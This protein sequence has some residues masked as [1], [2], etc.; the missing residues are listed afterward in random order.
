MSIRATGY[1]KALTSEN[2]PV[3]SGLAIRIRFLSTSLAAGDLKRMPDMLA[4]GE[5]CAKAPPDAKA[6]PAA[7]AAA[8]S[9]AAA[10]GAPAAMLAKAAAPKATAAVPTWRVAQS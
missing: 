4:M 8:L 9:A 5:M 10:A 6:A 2:G 7:A 3:S 1:G